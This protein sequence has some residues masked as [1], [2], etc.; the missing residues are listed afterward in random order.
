MRTNVLFAAEV[1]FALFAGKSSL[2]QPSYRAEDIVKHFAPPRLVATRGQ[3]IGTESECAKSVASPRPTTN[4]SF[5]RVVD[6][7][8]N[9][10]VLSA[11]AKQNLD[12]FAKALRDACL[13]SASFLVA[14]HTNAK[15]SGEFQRRPV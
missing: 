14:G 6:F 3:C 13:K 8:Y 2:A 1:G 11:Q 7:D 10:D 4:M 15:G 12:Q 9:S 5:N